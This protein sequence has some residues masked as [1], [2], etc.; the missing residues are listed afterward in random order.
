MFTATVSS[1][2]C[3]H[4]ERVPPR[5][6]FGSSLQERSPIDGTAPPGRRK[7]NRRASTLH[8]VTGR[9]WRWLAC[10][11]T[12]RPSGEG[13]GDTVPSRYHH[14]Y[15]RFVTYIISQ[16]RIPLTI[17]HTFGRQEER[18]LALSPPDIFH[19]SL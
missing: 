3:Q 9:A 12:I 8:V 10:D 11:G 7:S 17:R 16:K 14:R 18:T 15:V 6:T 5:G 19:V 1:V 4:S 13:Q 2:R